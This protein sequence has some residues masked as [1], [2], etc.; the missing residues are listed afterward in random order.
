MDSTLAS[1]GEQNSHPSAQ[2]AGS[3]NSK[4][5]I[6]SE[7]QR[8]FVTFTVEGRSYALDI[9]SVREIKAWSETTRL[10]HQ[11]SYMLGVLNLRGSIVPVQDL[12]NRFGLGRT[13]AN[14]S[15]V[16][17]IIVV[18]DRLLGILVDTVSDILTVDID[19]I[20]P[21]PGGSVNASDAFIE[22]LVNA[23]EGMVAI[24]TLPLLFADALRQSN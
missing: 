21:V 16:I 9:M 18:E 19:D 12:R 10:P 6:S 17:V 13:Q 23:D 2:S 14:D 11:P 4:R 3:G 5:V 20:R 1:S 15:H 22:G 7:N 24:L 8:Q